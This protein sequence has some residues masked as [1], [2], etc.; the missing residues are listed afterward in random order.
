MI[1]LSEENYTPF[2]VFTFASVINSTISTPASSKEIVS[3]YSR[4][5]QM[6]YGNVLV[7]NPEKL[8]KVGGIF[9]NIFIESILMLCSTPKIPIFELLPFGKKDSNVCSRIVQVIQDLSL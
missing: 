4:N 3:K 9:F 5:S 2:G 6:M 1:D 8:G 7:A